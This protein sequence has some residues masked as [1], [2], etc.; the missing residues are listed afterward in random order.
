MTTMAQYQ[1]STGLIID[2]MNVY[3]VCMY[4]LYVINSF[5]MIQL[6]FKS[7]ITIISFIIEPTCSTF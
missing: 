1:G 4:V 5:D 2:D 3:G 6:Q 7:N